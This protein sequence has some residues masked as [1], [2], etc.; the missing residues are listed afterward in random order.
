MTILWDWPICLCPSTL[1]PLSQDNSLRSY[2]FCNKVCN[3]SFFC[4]SKKS[5]DLNS[6]SISYRVYALFVLAM[7][8]CEKE[9]TVPPFYLSRLRYIS[10]LLPLL[11]GMCSE[12]WTSKVIIFLK[13]SLPLSF[14]FLKEDWCPLTSF[15]LGYVLSYG[16]SYFKFQSSEFYA[17]KPFRTDLYVIKAYS[18]SMPKDPERAFR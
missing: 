4:K 16:L 8:D 1:R 9:S 12:T 3:S 13:R 11:P 2:V 5:T 18:I 15:P 17:S 14:S 6:V 7:G 10:F